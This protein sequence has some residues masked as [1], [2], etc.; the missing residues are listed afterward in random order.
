MIEYGLQ[1]YSV[2]DITKENL[3]DALR[4]VAEMGYTYVEFAGF[5]GNTAE[6][7]KAWMDEYGLK[8]SGTHTSGDLISPWKIKDTIAYHKAIGCTNLIVPSAKWKTVEEMEYNMALFNYAQ[9]KLAEEGISLGYHNHSGEFYPTPYGKIV[10]DE[11]MARTSIDIEIDTFWLFN[12]GIDPVPYLEAHKDRIKV[13]H[14]KDGTVLRD[15]NGSFANARNGA[16]GK[17]VGSGM[18]PVKAVRDWA[19]QNGVLMVIESEGL[20]PTG[21]AEVKRCIDFLRSLEA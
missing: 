17:S 2:R 11:I 15:G 20:D 5:F 9:K 18:A 4:Q 13:I 8:C 14:L 7:V 3:K 21:P 16:E 1:M 19:I 6:D 12:A 10:E